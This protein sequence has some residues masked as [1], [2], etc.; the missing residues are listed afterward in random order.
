MNERSA[1]QQL[2]VEKERLLLE[3]TKLQR[4][5][6]EFRSGNTSGFGEAAGGATGGAAAYPAPS[7][8]DETRAISV[9][10]C[11]ICNNWFND[12]DTLVKHVD[13]CL[14]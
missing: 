14:T 7:L 4:R 9:H 11:P 5:E 8:M 1:R 10:I 12:I 3:L 6:F 2:T 13:R